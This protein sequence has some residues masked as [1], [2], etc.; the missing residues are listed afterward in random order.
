[1][2]T[3]A[4]TYSPVKMFLISLVTIFTA[5]VGIM[6][7]IHYWFPN[8]DPVTE[9]FV[10]GTLLVL[11]VF[12]IL[13]FTIFR[14]MNDAIT[15]LQ[16]QSHTL[17]TFR[18]AIEHAGHSVVITDK[19][20]TIEYVNPAVEEVTGFEKDEVIGRN[21]RIW[22]SEEHD[23]QFYERMWDVILSGQTFKAEVVNTKKNGDNFVIHQT[24]APIFDDEGE[25]SR[26]VGIYQDV[27]KLKNRERQLREQRNNAQRLR[28]R[29]S[30]LN[31]ILRHDIRSGVTVIQGHAAI[32]EDKFGSTESVSMI[33]DEIS[34]LQRLSE[35][36]RSIEQTM[37]EATPIE[38]V[39]LA[40]MLN[41]HVDTKRSAHPDA[42]LTIDVPPTLTAR[43]SV[44]FERALEQVL[45][46]AI[47][48]NDSDEP[49]VHVSGSK[50]TD[51]KPAVEIEVID[52]GPG[53]PEHELEALGEDESQLAHM[54]GLGLWETY[55]IVDDSGGSLEFESDPETGTTV[56]I[57]LPT[58]TQTDD[59]D[60][61]RSGIADGRLETR[62]HE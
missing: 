29:L 39:E 19:E 17:E 41:E 61:F 60:P 44:Q 33:R 11:L 36:A 7:A 31:R 30:V 48:H 50:T 2:D 10:D 15:Q 51:P 13:F 57:R 8:I 38:T 4:S 5:E 32:L 59:R 54:S 25:I 35:Q 6:F 24:I 46:N 9:A 37:A 56:T 12:P 58:P 1:M 49:T 14:P 45:S 16:D 21:P 43:M 40:E 28:Q 20:G 52:N 3:G 18:E 55:W 26:F 47:E 23:E 53:I 27:T 34:R 62:D 42:S 22:K